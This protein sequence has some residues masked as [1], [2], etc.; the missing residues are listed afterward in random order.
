[1]AG[2]FQ[3]DVIIKAMI[4]LSIEEM[5]K[6]PWLLDHAFESLNVLRYTSD[7]YKGNIQAAK[8][9]FAKNKIDAYLRPRNDK[10]ILPFVSILPGPSQEKMEMKHMG[11]IST[12]TKMLLPNEIGQPIPY[13]VK[14]FAPLGYVQST[15]V[16]TVPENV[17][18]NIIVPGQVLVNPD[19]GTGYIIQDIQAN[20][21]LVEPG[22]DII[23]SQLGV[24]PKYQMYKARVEHT[25]NQETYSI[26]CYAHGDPQNL[27][28]LHTIVYYAIM[29]YR[30]ALLEGNGFAESVVSSGDIQEDPNFPGPDG[31]EAFVRFITIAGQ[32]EQSWIKAPKRFIESV[33][34]TIQI[35]TNENTPPILNP[36]TEPWTT[37]V[38]DDSDEE[39]S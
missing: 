35:I 25:F 7:K 24:I 3:G 6:N 32:V 12:V 34:P 8:E 10:D 19:N 29:R 28:W 30:E 31:E 26:G 27:I 2:V 17:S 20:S 9:W 36:S 18:L 37:V 21:I 16:L 4:D 33:T 11:D 39:E 1:M 13:I 14:P 15:G 5:R 23:A 22:L 38:D